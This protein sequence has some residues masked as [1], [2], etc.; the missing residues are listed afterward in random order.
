MSLPAEKCLT[1][2]SFPRIQINAVVKHPLPHEVYDKLPEK[3]LVAGLPGWF[4]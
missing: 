4:G 1:F 2:S 3:L